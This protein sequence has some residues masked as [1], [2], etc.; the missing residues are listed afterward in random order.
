MPKKT[1]SDTLTAMF[2]SPKET[3]KDREAREKK[4]AETQTMIAEQKTLPPMS[5][6][7]WRE[8]S[9]ESGIGL[10]RAAKDYKKLGFRSDEETM[11]KAYDK[12]KAELD[13]LQRNRIPR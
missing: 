5:E 6:E 3:E 4:F 8:Q 1:H 11:G 9:I 7:E 2:T 10:M 12:L 13:E